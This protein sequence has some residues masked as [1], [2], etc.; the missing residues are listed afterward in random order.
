MR[1]Q[2]LD[3]LGI[4]AAFEGMARLR[5]GDGRRF[6]FPGKRLLES[7]PLEKSLRLGEPLQLG[8]IAQEDVSGMFDDRRC[9]LLD[10]CQLAL[11]VST[12]LLFC[13]QALSELK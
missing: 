12:P 11:P 3:D 1:L 7:F 13:G 4:V 6:L 2:Q 10:L 8:E 9:R 5:R